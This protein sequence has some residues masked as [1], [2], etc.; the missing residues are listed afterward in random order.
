MERARRRE[1][2]RLRRAAL[3]RRPKPLEDGADPFGI[4]ENVEL[5]DP[6]ANPLDPRIGETGGADPLGET[7]AQIDVPGRGDIAD[8][9]DNF[10]VIDDAPTV[11]SGERVCRL[12]VNR[13]ANALPAVSLARAYPDLAHED[14]SAHGDRIAGTF[15]RDC[16]AEMGPSAFGHTSTMPG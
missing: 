12:K 15:C 7:L 1:L 6:D 11:F 13:N 4:R 3:R 10:F 8:C 2:R 9:R 5:L 14:K 16:R